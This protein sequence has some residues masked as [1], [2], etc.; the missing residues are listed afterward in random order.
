MGRVAAIQ[1]TSSHIVADNLAAAG[2]VEPGGANAGGRRAR[3][4]LLLVPGGLIKS[5]LMA[6]LRKMMGW[7][8]CKI[9]GVAL[10]RTCLV[11][12]V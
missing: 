4:V 12:F 11:P 6:I 8:A 10:M 1:M 9:F 7:V 5:R 3:K 2:G